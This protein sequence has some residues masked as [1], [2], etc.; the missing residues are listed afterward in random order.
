[1]TKRGV[2]VKQAS[3]QS[4]TKQ[5]I[6]DQKFSLHDFEF[7]NKIVD[8]ASRGQTEQEVDS[9]VVA[10]PTCICLNLEDLRC[11]EAVERQY[12]QWGVLFNNCIAI[13]PSNP[14]FP[15]HSGLVVLMGAR[16]NESLEATFLR[17]VHFVS[18]FVT[19]S[20]RLVLSAY[21][22]D[23]QLLTQTVLP[24]ANLANSE[25]AASPNT[26]LSVSA[27]EIYRVTFCAFDGQFT[28]DDFS[29]CY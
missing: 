28:I 13:Q 22:R 21:G 15:T 1:M 17:P 25:C 9:E 26:L 16:K 8:Y 29:F 10:V 11:F 7:S 2:V 23:R 5:T 14:A 24:G 18:A 4:Q 19:S 3:L 6:E 27:N 12:E 20:Q